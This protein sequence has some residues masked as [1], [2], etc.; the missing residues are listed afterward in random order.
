MTE[1]PSTSLQRTGD[2]WWQRSAAG[3][4][5]VGRWVWRRTG[6]PLKTVW[7]RSTAPAV[8][9]WRRFARPFVRFFAQRRGGL[10]ILLSALGVIIVAFVSIWLETLIKPDS[11]QP[12]VGSTALAWGVLFL[13]L[14]V[15]LLDIRGR[16]AYQ[17]GTLVYLRLLSEYMT[18]LHNIASEARERGYAE[19]KIV[20]RWIDPRAK[21][22]HVVEMV[23][24][25]QAITFEAER[26]MNE[27]T[28][29]TGTHLAPNLVW[30]AAMAVGYDLAEVGS[31]QVELIELAPKPAV[32]QDKAEEQRGP[33]PSLDW[34]I[35]AGVSAVEGS[36]IPKIVRASV[37]NRA[38][39]GLVQLLVELT[40]MGSA[41]KLQWM[42][43]VT[44]RVAAFTDEDPQK[45][46][47]TRVEVTGAGA[48]DVLMGL[49]TKRVTV[50]DGRAGSDDQA[51]VRPHIAAGVVW[52]VI[53]DAL[54]DYPNSYLMLNLRVPKTVGLAIGSLLA[55]SGKSLESPGCGEDCLQESCRNPWGRL[56]PLNYVRAP[57]PYYEVL[58][59]H[60]SQP[61]VEEINALLGA[62]EKDATATS[63]VNLTPHT[64]R[65]M[66]ASGPDAV[67]PATG[68]VA[69][70]REVIGGTTWVTASEGRFPIQD[71]SYADTVDDLPDS[72]PGVLYLVS[73]V[74]A[75]AVDR[76][77]LVFPQGEL[78]D[79]RGAIIGCRALGTFHPNTGAGAH[80]A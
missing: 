35:R 24:E 65:V 22:G 3:L 9:L 23:T 13:I 15:A 39:I 21:V 61:T 72:Q 76:A 12:G 42:P 2:R 46:F 63:V 14:G 68:A 55:T 43:D 17:R 77:D 37:S 54:H 53:R 32:G 34:R 16:V 51:I 71:V 74:T 62:P 36:E 67:F 45:E 75:A 44:V 31:G 19:H 7:R 40:P 6:R 8:A 5:T 49:A 60:R 79:A 11:E 18:D 58:R 70:V 25:V 59:V 26:S 80:D 52:R 64:V 30:P 66:P 4:K 27:D 33:S 38:D 47:D 48:V 10:D 41:A 28:S 57:D 73:R 78:R 1:R 20:S 50:G 29:A 56:L 69:R